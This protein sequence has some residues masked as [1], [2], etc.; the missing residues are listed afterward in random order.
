M[1]QLKEAVGYKNIREREHAFITRAIARW[2][3]NP[4]LQILGNPDGWRLS[5]VSFMVRHRSTSTDWSA[6]PGRD[7]KRKEGELRLHHNFVVALLN[8]LFGLQARGGCSCAGPYG[9]RLLH[10]DD[11]QS[12]KFEAAVVKGCTGVRPGWV[13]IN[14][15]YF[16]S[17]HVFDFVVRAV[18]WVAEHGWKLLPDYTFD[19]DSGVWRHKNGPQ[20]AAMRLHS[21][22]YRSGKMEF[23][24]RLQTEPEFAVES[25]FGEANRA[26][27]RAVSVCCETDLVP[28]ILPETVESLRWFLMPHEVVEEMRASRLA[29]A[30]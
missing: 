23:R 1:F 26:A 28:E 11:A 5:I 16:I 29:V 10:I 7:G 27:E 22:S 4:N 8:D 30:G 14:F 9:H 15:N 3:S 21:V 19:P 2:R 6:G 25:Y 13:R 20:E 18:E 24:S 17:E 12:A